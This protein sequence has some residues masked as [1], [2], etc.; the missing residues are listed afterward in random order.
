M[1][2]TVMMRMHAFADD[3]L[4]TRLRC[5]TLLTRATT[6]GAPS[7]GLPRRG[8]QPSSSARPMRCCT[9]RPMPVSRMCVRWQQR[10]DLL[11]EDTAVPGALHTG[12]RGLHGPRLHA[13]KASPGGAGC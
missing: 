5:R 7:C 4:L 1:R 8:W 3:V 11:R 13:G 10:H 6:R 2:A 9:S 12:Q